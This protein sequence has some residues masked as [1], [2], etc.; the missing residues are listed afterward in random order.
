MWKRI[1]QAKAVSIASFAAFA[2]AL[3]GWLWAAF[4]LGAAAN[5]GGAGAA[6]GAA[7]AGGAS[8]PVPLILHFN[9]LSGI[10][11]VGGMGSIAFMGILGVAVAVMNFAVALELYRRDRF[12]GKLTAAVTLAFAALLFIAF[13]AIISANG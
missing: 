5:A 7:G 11:A 12:L 9:N 2:L 8:A 3:G 10:T 6:S 13:A 4:A 1:M